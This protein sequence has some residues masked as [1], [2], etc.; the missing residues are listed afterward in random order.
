MNNIKVRTTSIYTK[1]YDINTVCEK[2]KNGEIKY[3]LFDTLNSRDY[4]TKSSYWKTTIIESMLM[5][6]PMN[7]TYGKYCDCNVTKLYNNIDFFKL[8]DEFVIK[9]KYTL[10]HCEIY[11]EYEGYNFS[12]LPRSQQRRILEQQLNFYIIEYGA[13]DSTVLQLRNQIQSILE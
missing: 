1:I 3:R 12:M 6:M 9:D 8:L 2:M 11:P 13:S 4:K 10:K 5:R 7:I